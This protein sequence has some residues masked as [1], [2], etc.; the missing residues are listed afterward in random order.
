MI[1]GIAV[2]ILFVIEVPIVHGHQPQFAGFLGKFFRLLQKIASEPADQHHQ[3]VGIRFHFL[4]G[5]I[6]VR[7]FHRDLAITLVLLAEPLPGDGGA[8]VFRADENYVL[9]GIDIFDGLDAGTAV[10]HQLDGLPIHGGLLGN[11]GLAREFF[12]F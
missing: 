1:N 10:G 6:V 12:L 11:Q 5:S 9:L 8:G 2:F 3:G 7:M 4:Q